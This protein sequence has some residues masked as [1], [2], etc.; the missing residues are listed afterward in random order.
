L[1]WLTSKS[2]ADDM[3]DGIAHWFSASISFT[4]IG[5]LSDWDKYELGHNVL[6]FLIRH[7]GYHVNED[8]ASLLPHPNII[9]DISRQIKDDKGSSWGGNF[10]NLHPAILVHMALPKFGILRVVKD[11]RVDRGY[12][13]EEELPSPIT[14]VWAAREQNVHLCAVLAENE[15]DARSKAWEV[16]G[17]EA[18]R[19][20]EGD[21]PLEI[22][23]PRGADA[24]LAAFVQWQETGMAIGR[25]YIDASQVNS[26]VDL[27]DP[28]ARFREGWTQ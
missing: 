24:Y 4:S 19:I 21:T 25:K 22:V 23:S 13:L 18:C 2:Y 1:D 15:Q 9:R 11:N 16:I 14:D 5:G 6:T 17:K 20:H 7:F 8:L 3:R 10:S 12:C 27:L 26:K 28:S